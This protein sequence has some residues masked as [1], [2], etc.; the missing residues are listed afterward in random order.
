MKR[1]ALFTHD[2]YGLGHVRR[3][4]RILRALAE[5]KPSASLLLITGSPST[6]LLRDLPPNADTLK[7]PTVITSGG[8]GTRPSTLNMGVAELCSLRGELTRKALDVFEP[9]VLLVDNFPLG[10]RLELLPTLREMRHRPTRTVL[11]LRDVVDPPEKVRKDWE[12]DGLFDVVERYYDRVIVYGIP[13]VLDAVSAYGLSDEVARKLVYCGYVTENGPASG[14]PDEISRRLGVDPGFLL[15]TVGGGGDGRPL[16]E[17]FVGALERFPG[18]Q[19]V[20]VTGE[21]MSPE[22]RAAVR[23]AAA[24]RNGVVVREH[25]A[26][27]PSAMR[28]A[29]LVVSMGGYN[30]SAEILATRVRSVVVPRTWR[31]GEHGAR[32]KTGVDAEQLVRAEGLARLGLVTTLDPRKLSAETLADAMCSALKAPPHG[33]SSDLELDGAERVAQQLVALSQPRQDGR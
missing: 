9:D 8:S 15:A 20:V 24:E 28:A 7:I 2:A 13:A 29:E 16:L 22:D 12:R 19:A 31:S 3:S 11:G 23:R 30:T 18:R 5:L 25:I 27:L 26:D 21:F 32:G 1:F 6:H 14:T 10:T 17:A 33:G 4:T